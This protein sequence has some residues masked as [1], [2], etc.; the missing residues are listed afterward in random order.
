MSGIGGA[1][2][3]AGAGGNGGSVSTPVSLTIFDEVVFYDGYA[4]VVDEPVAAGV[5]RLRNDL[6]THKLSDEELTAIQNTLTL[7]VVVGALCDNYDRIGS[8]ALALVPAGES[9]YAPDDV[10]R[11]EVGRFVTPFMDWNKQPDEVSYQYEAHEL[12]PVLHDAALRAAYDL[13]LEL[14]LFGV[15]YAANTEVAGC[16][17]RSDVFRGTL[18]LDSDSSAPAVD[19]GTLIPVSYKAPFNDYQAGASDMIGTTRKTVEFVL[20][21]DTVETELVLII[22]NHG[23][24]SGGEEYS[25]RDHF[26][27]VDDELELMFRPG[28]ASCEPFRMFNTQANGIYGPSPRSD[29]SWQSFSNW[30]PGDIIDTRVIEL[31]SM[32]A[33]RHEFVIDVPDAQ[34]A[35]GEG[36]F[37]FSLYVQSRGN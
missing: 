18:I 35:G 15:P 25:R 33:G 23:A 11:I 3:T 34:F 16:S 13:W 30:C 9:S 32:S 36:N 37:P 12:V 14:E 17:N 4:S 8:V 2:G 10:E 7:R 20:D 29:G 31:G 5:Q 22:S 24:N 19:F 6:F 1:G 26:V 28:R 27:Y 21:A